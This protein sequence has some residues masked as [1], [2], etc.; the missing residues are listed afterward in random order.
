MRD[1]EPGAPNSQSSISTSITTVLGFDTGVPARVKSI[2]KSYRRTELLMEEFSRVGQKLNAATTAEEAGRIILGVADKIW[3]WDCGY[4][5]LYSE[6]TNQVYPIVA[7]DIVKGKKTE[8]PA[9]RTAICPSPGIVQVIEKGAQLIL[10]SPEAMRLNGLRPFGD[11]S[12]LSASIMIVPVRDGKKLTAI[13]SIDS[14][15]F[16]AYTRDDLKTLQAL[17][18]HCGGALQRIW[19]QEALRKSEEQLRA[20]AARLQ[21]A[22][23]EEGIRIAREIHDE[24]GQAMT[25]LK[26][27]LHCLQKVA[28][29]GK[30]VP[31]A[32]VSAKIKDMVGIVNQTITTV[33][34]ICGELRPGILDDLGLVPAMEW[35]ARE[36]QTRTGILCDLALPKEPITLDQSRATAVFRIFQEIL[37]NIARHSKANR[38]KITLQR[39]KRTLSLSAE[40]DGIGISDE[41]ISGSKSLGLIGMRERALVFGG[42]IHIARRK[43]RGTI[44][45]VKIPLDT[46]TTKK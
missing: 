42:E 29:T 37:T 32:E 19:A 24:L 10:R 30:A 22:R 34:R 39:S 28:T 33:R 46:Y 31:T 1:A 14:Y 13:L 38:T 20:L 5:D 16:N 27:D 8:I 44:V 6:E 43:P 4:L 41:Q 15:S 45:R 17:A 23:E 21:K 2:L 9:S 26:L 12:R 40:D 3:D 18:D 36:F 35:Q 11:E 25:G 7:F